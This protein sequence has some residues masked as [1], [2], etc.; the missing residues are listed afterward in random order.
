MDWIHQGL[1]A[2]QILCAFF[3]GGFIG[4]EREKNRL[5]AG[6][7]TYAAVC[8][9]AAMFTIIGT[10]TQPIFFSLKANKTAEKKGA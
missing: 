2:L 3:L 10:S 6:I 7:R 9:G 8:M 1:V 5:G 4:F